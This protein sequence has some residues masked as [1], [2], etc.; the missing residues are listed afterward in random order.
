M[1][2]PRGK[3][4]EIGKAPK[5]IRRLGYS[6]AYQLGKYTLEQYLGTAVACR[7]LVPRSLAGPESYEKLVDVFESAVAQAVL[8][9]PLLQV[10]LVGEHSR[11]PTWIQLESVDFRNHVEW[12]AAE[13]SEE[14]DRLFCETLQSQLDTEFGNLGSR[15]G[16]RMSVLHQKEAGFLEVVYCFNHPAS[17]GTG[18]KIFHETLLRCLKNRAVDDARPRILKDRV[19]ELPESLDHFIPAQHKVTKFPITVGYAAKALWRDARPPFL[20]KDP[21]HATWAPYRTSPNKTRLGWFRIDQPA[22]QRVLAECRRQRTTLTGLLH[23]LCLISLAP[24]LG[25]SEARA[26]AAMTAV[27][28]RQLLPS[29]PPAYPWL[30]LNKAIGNFSSA[31]FHEFDEELVAMARSYTRGAS[32]SD[33]PLDEPLKSIAW[34]VASG[35]RRKIEADLRLGVKN[36]ILSLMKFVDLFGGWKA[37]LKD[38]VRTP[39]E[40]S[41]LVTNLGVLDGTVQGVTSEGTEDGEAWHI[42]HAQFALCADVASAVFQL[43]PIAVKGGDL[44]VYCSWQESVVDSGLAERFVANLERWMKHLGS[45]S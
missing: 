19:L 24:Q 30:E 8:E 11:T 12:K 29:N 4:D 5:V 25:K 27:N 22:L 7:Y 40:L 3:R 23:A 43:S 41:W 34:E 2:R 37:H 10:G 18:A 26:F 17:D 15:P 38:H 20:S 45:P 36:N 9:H 16:W 39:R 14:F 32:T 44:V 1:S 13:S 6:E 31:I 21:S 33:L 42:S 28:T 35:V